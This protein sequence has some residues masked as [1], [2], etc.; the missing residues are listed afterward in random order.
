M[1]SFAER[2]CGGAAIAVS[3]R[4]LF[5]LKHLTLTEMTIPFLCRISHRWRGL[6]GSKRNGHSPEKC[7]RCGIRR[8]YYGTNGEGCHGIPYFQIEPENNLRRSITLMNEV[9]AEKDEL[10][11]ELR[12]LRSKKTTL[13]VKGRVQ[14]HLE[15]K[16]L[17]ADLER[18]LA[19][20][21]D[22]QPAWREAETRL[23]QGVEAI[24]R[25]AESL[26]ENATMEARDK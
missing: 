7:L 11:D 23:A 22:A 26:H 13:I 8:D 21:D 18:V 20:K 12:A 6:D 10:A 4:L 9:L 25:I 19:T 14:C 24:K 17:E 1:F 5:S 2:L 3:S 16:A 15:I